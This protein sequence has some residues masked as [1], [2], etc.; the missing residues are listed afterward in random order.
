MSL[1]RKAVLANEDANTAMYEISA[2]IPPGTTREQ[3]DHMLQNLLIERFKLAYHYEKKEMAVLDLA[4]GKG[5]LKMKASSRL[6]IGAARVSKR[7]SSWLSR[8]F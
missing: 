2:K 8:R 1:T 6:P 4:I 7:F 3:F 5:A